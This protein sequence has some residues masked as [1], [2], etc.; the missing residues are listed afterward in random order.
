MIMNRILLP[1]LILL[2]SLLYSWFWNCERKPYCSVGDYDGQ[3]SAIVA[4]AIDDNADAIVEQTETEV[5]TEAQEEELLFKPLDIYFETA[6]S[7]IG[8]SPEIIDFIS[9]AKKYL[10]AHPDK[11]LSIVGHTDSD[12][13]DATNERLSVKRANLLKEHLVSDGFSASQLVVTGKGESEPIA[14]NDTPE[15]RA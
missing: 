1:V 9:T 11:Q 7:E 4:P 5:R 8:Q 10:A 14:S 13:T 12:G 3:N 2:W 6:Q 15:G